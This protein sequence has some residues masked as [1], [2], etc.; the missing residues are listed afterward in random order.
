[1]SDVNSTA[2][3]SYGFTESE[4][5][6]ALAYRERFEPAETLE[7]RPAG[8]PS[9]KEVGDIPAEVIRGMVSAEGYRRTIE[10]ETGGKSYYERRLKRPSWPGGASGV[11][12]GV[13]YDV[14]YHSEKEVAADWGDQIAAQ[15][16]ELLLS[17]VGF[18]GERARA[19]VGGLAQIAVPWEVAEV[20]FV[21]ATLPK[22]A[23]MV[24]QNLLNVTELHPHC[25]GALFSLV[26]NR[27][28]SFYNAGDRFAEMRNIAR[29]MQTKTF[30]KIPAEIV[31]MKRLWGSELSGLH[32]RRDAEAALF[33]KGLEEASKP[34]PPPAA[35]TA[36]AP[37]AV[38]APAGPTIAGTTQPYVAPQGFESAAK[39]AAE[40]G[41][42]VV[43]EA[44]EDWEDREAR[45][46]AERLPRPEAYKGEWYEAH[47]VSWIKDDTRA[48]DY[49]HIPDRA[50]AGRDFAMTAK[51]LDLLIAANRFQPLRNEGRILFALRGCRLAGDK[52]QI[53][54]DE[55][56]L[57]E[58]RPDH[59]NF[60][61]VIGVYN[62]SNM[63]L[64]GFV[65]ST[66]PYFTA[67]HAGWEKEANKRRPPSGNMLSTG[68]YPY[69]V[70][71]H[72]A[73]QIPGCFL[74]GTSF[75]KRAKVIVLRTHN[76]V[77]Y[78]TDD[79]WH[80]CVPHDNLHPAFK[81][82]GFSSEG[83]QT[84][85]GTY[86]NGSHTADFAAL[87][88]AA[89]LGKGKDN[90]KRIDYMLL[91]GLEAAIASSLRERGLA[92]DKGLVD[93]M[94]GRLR[95]GS[96]GEEVKR[97][98][99][100]LG[101]PVTGLLDAD[102]RDALIKRQ[103]SKLQ[104]ADAVYSPDWDRI[105]GLNVF[106]PTAP[107]SDP[108]AVPVAALESARAGGMVAITDDRTSRSLEDER[109]FARLKALGEA[110]PDSLLYEIGLRSRIAAESG[111]A[112]AIE[113]AAATGGRP[114]FGFSALRSVGASI[115]GRVE[116]D[117]HTVLC[118]GS[119][120]D[121]ETRDHIARAMARA[122]R[123]P[124]PPAVDATAV[125]VDDAAGE[126]REESG[127]RGASPVDIDTLSRILVARLGIL[128]L[129]AQPI[130][131]LLLDQVFKSTIEETCEA[132]RGRLGGPAGS[133]A[134]SAAAAG[135]TGAG[136]LAAGRMQALLATPEDQLLASIA[137]ESRMSARGAGASRELGF[138][139]MPSMASLLT[140]GRLV[141]NMAEAQLYLM[142]CGDDP[143]SSAVRDSIGSLYGMHGMGDRATIASAIGTLLVSQ[144]GFI[145]FVAAP[146]AA[147][148][149][150]K[151]FKAGLDETCK[152]WGAARG[153][154][155]GA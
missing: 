31:A 76:D 123:K 36:A 112:G 16:L 20:V 18:K 52:A 39:E 133:Q 118:G 106:A 110:S 63:R 120:Q 43:A 122:V 9:A 68:L 90:G 13:G 109:A 79:Y 57:K 47:E 69:V 154:G 97:L 50:L 23:R 144:L 121:A 149:V 6:R 44:R 87:R 15:H 22:Y 95:Q 94:L 130:A 46:E 12:I 116:R 71:P 64:S 146:I 41:V 81:S 127:Q 74:Q 33:R 8:L 4:F 147:L 37:A 148:L 35:T 34:K 100:A 53:D 67:V 126:A 105:L 98:Q 128:P 113:A 145:P 5:E 82:S 134:E 14:G 49:R 73:R 25:F 65:S 2:L 140:G 86:A 93:E 136:A 115:F 131:A 59:R 70:G 48:P 66:V 139:A 28:P 19:L 32:K 51:D 54:V 77:T 129:L 80:L 45:L 75:D 96:H 78:D 26:F 99:A 101:R 91:T 84:V 124:A 150:S 104:L 30:D 61:C 56:K 72:G 141:Y 155:P 1:M 85:R 42:E 137:R 103:R 83:C 135:Q 153:T 114:E 62:T 107:P 111:R 151:F 55:L 143:N 88:A 119:D 89:G 3:E 21:R 17:T 92:G 58:S 11:T 38:A 152:H 125:A 102:D 7:A 10:F 132:W 24:V 60:R 29:H 138:E 27:G 40:A 108:L 142:L 117:L